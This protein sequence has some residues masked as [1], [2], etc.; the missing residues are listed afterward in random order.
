MNLPKDSDAWEVWE[1]CGKLAL[2]GVG[3]FLLLKCNGGE[4]KVSHDKSDVVI[5]SWEWW[6]FKQTETPIVW[7][8]NHWMAKNEKGGWYVAVEEPE[9]DPPESRP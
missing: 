3:I 8:E 9:Y 2:I 4:I 5:H 7:R 6:G 1:S